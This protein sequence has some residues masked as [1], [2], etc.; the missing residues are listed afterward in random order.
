MA[1][2]NP[3]SRQGASPASGAPAG[4]RSAE[5]ERVRPRAR[6]EEGDLEQPLAAAVGLTHQLIQTL[7]GDRAVA[8]GVGI[9]AVVGA[10]RLAVDAD[11]VADGLAVTCEAKH[12]VQIAA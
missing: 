8:V 6:I 3:G 1:L 11:A 9:H 2:A 4:I 5:R 7:A 10:R 12:Q